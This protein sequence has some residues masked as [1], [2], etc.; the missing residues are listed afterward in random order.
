MLRLP[1]AAPGLICLAR[2]PASFTDIASPRLSASAQ[3][4]H[5]PLCAAHRRPTSCACLQ[6]H[7]PSPAPPALYGQHKQHKQHRSQT[8]QHQKLQSQSPF[9]SPRCGCACEFEGTFVTISRGRHAPSIPLRS[10]PFRSSSASLPLRSRSIHVSLHFHSTPGHCASFRAHDFPSKA[11]SQCVFLSEEFL[12]NENQTREGDTPSNPSG[13][14]DCSEQLQ[15]GKL[16][17]SS[18]QKLPRFSHSEPKCQRHSLEAECLFILSLG[19]SHFT[20]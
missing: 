10:L 4:S 6:G 16:K 11:A 2:Q 12:R 19:T 3:R 7:S 15:R 14:L 18:A 20:L 1:P 8:H 9:N 13:K 17:N 5:E